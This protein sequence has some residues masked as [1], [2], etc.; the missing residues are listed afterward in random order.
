VKV[1]EAM[2]VDVVTVTPDTPAKQAF[3]L[4]RTGKFHHLPVVD[5]RGKIVGIV[6]DRDIR[7]VAVFFDKEARNTTDYH[8]S[9]SV[10]TRE[11]MTKNPVTVAPD[12]DLGHASDLMAKHNFGGLPVAENGKVVGILTRF[13]LMKLL[14]KLL[15]SA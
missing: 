8:I 10:V 4:M 13:D 9:P 1:K 14:A 11:I 3:E 5:A 6:S 7:N 15:K 12:D 2:R